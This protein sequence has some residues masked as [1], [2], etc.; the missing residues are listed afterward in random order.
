VGARPPV[1]PSEYLSADACG[2]PPRCYCRVCLLKGCDQ[3]F[4]PSH[5]LQRYCS[6]PCQEA[7]RQW[8]RWQ[9]ARR[10]RTTPQGQQQRREQSR[11]YRD[12]QRARWATATAEPV[13]MEP[14]PE[15]RE[16]QR[17]GDV[18]ED[19]SARPCQRP[20][21]YELFVPQP[22]EPPQ[23]FCCSACRR[24]LR[25]VLQREARWRRRHHWIRAGRFRP[26]PRC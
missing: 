7:A 14:V 3:S 18:S 4:Q 26:P 22:H 23:R 12:R 6:Q 16:G 19:L 9:A 1:G 2:Q 15:Q 13:V 10:Y 20:G 25:R 11:R 21:C 8:R 5:P 24:A 17:Y